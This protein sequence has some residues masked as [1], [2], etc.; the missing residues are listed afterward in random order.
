MDVA[1]L[2]IHEGMY[3]FAPLKFRSYWTEIHQIGHD[4]AR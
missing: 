4:V 2:L 1:K 3:I